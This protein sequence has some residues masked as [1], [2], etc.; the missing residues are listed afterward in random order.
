MKNYL[1]HSKKFYF[2]ILFGIQNYCFLYYKNNKSNKKIK[3]IIK[4]QKLYK[5]KYISSQE[6]QISSYNPKKNTYFP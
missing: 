4:E 1:N 5:N 6:F 3:K 2:F